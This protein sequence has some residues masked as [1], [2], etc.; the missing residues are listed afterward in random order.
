M[1]RFAVTISRRTLVCAAVVAAL[2]LSSYA[3]AQSP[4]EEMGARF[5]MVDSNGVKLRIAEMGR[6]PDVT[7]ISHPTIMRVLG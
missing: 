6:G 7:P 5:R 4:A 3:Q 2:A 1:R